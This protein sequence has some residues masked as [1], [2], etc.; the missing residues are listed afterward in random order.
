MSETW[1]VIAEI[2]GELQ[3]ELLR[4][5][6]KAQGIL[7][8]LNQEGAGRAYGLNVGPLGL[9]QIMVP[10]SSVEDARHVL[11]DYYAGNFETPNEEE[12]DDIEEDE[13]EQDN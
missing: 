7:V 5:L 4:G 11:A 2:Y 12:F 9:V 8:V 1:E 3:A 6:L 13:D 10:A